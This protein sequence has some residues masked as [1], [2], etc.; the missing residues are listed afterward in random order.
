LLFNIFSSVSNLNDITKVSF[1]SAFTSPNNLG[2]L[3][4]EITKLSL[5]SFDYILCSAISFCGMKKSLTE[6]AK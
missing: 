2:T 5:Y 4:K 1:A 6:A 3:F